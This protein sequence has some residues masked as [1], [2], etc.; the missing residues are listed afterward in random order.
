MMFVMSLS[1]DHSNGVFL[2]YT[3][4]STF[5]RELINNSNVWTIDPQWSTCTGYLA[6]DLLE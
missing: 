5:Q 6:R 3:A 2:I 4:E 1:T